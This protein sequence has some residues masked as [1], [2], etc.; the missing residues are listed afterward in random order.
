[1]EAEEE[2][3]EE[4]AGAGAGLPSSRGRLTRAQRASYAVLDDSQEERYEERAA[5]FE[6]EHGDGHGAGD[7]PLPGG[8]AV[9]AFM[10]TQLLPFQRDGVAWL[11]GLHRAGLGGILGDEM[12]LG[13]T[14]QAVALLGTLAA[15]GLLR[16]TLI[17]CPATVI[18]HWVRELTTWWPPLRVLVL[19]D[20]G[21]A[22]SAAGGRADKAATR[23][24]V[25]QTV[26]ASNAIL[27]TTYDAVRQHSELLTRPKWGYAI[28][29]EGHRIRN[30]EAAV[31]AAVKSLHTV[32][33]IVLSGAPIQ[34]RLQELW[35]LFDFVHPGRLGSLSMFE[36]QFT[37]PIAAGGWAHAT[38]LQ[39]STAVQCALVL[40]DLITPGLLRRLKRDVATQ[41][42]TK[43]EQVLFCRLS[44]AQRALYT[45]YLRSQEVA[46][47]LD[48]GSLA[49]RPITVLRK[50]CNH[51]RLLQVGGGGG[52]RTS[53]LVSESGKMS[54]LAE[55]MRMWR[56]EKRRCLLFAQGTAMLDLLEEYV[57]SEGWPYLRMD[58]GTAI[59]NRQVL[60]DAFNKDATWFV[61]LLTTRVGGVGVNLIGADRVVIFDPDWNPS[62]DTQARERA[63]RLGQ[64]K[65]VTIYRLITAGTIE[66]KIYKRQVFKTV[67]TQRVLV[68]P[69]LKRQF[70]YAD[71][72]DLFTLVDEGAGAG[73]GAAGEQEQG[74]PYEEEQWDSDE[75][76]KPSRPKRGRKRA[77]IDDEE[78]E[79]E[80]PVSRPTEPFG[81][82]ALDHLEAFHDPDAD[83]GRGVPRSRGE[84]GEEG[85][86]DDFEEEGEGEGGGRPT[87]TAVLSDIVDGSAMGT[88]ALAASLLTLPPAER[89]AISRAAV[90]RGEE[91]RRA[92]RPPTPAAAAA[93][94]APPV[95]APSPA[96]LPPLLPLAPARAPIPPTAFLSVTWGALVNRACWVGA[97]DP[98]DGTALIWAAAPNEDAAGSAALA[99]ACVTAARRTRST[100]QFPPSPLAT[101][102]PA[103]TR[104]SPGTTLRGLFFLPSRAA[105]AG[106]EPL[107]KRPGVVAAAGKTGGIVVRAWVP[108]AQR[109][110]RP[111]RPTA[112]PGFGDAGESG[113][114]ARQGAGTLRSRAI[115]ARMAD[116]R[117]AGAK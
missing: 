12:G 48:G 21:D 9:P 61:F 71:L 34:N 60:V 95:R 64:R 38:V 55:I 10:A 25:V 113:L 54:V 90:R 75:E 33:R 43:T 72:R 86:E 88:D 102:P 58:G 100:A 108:M 115:L 36:A 27:I 2:E 8:L 73:A 116:L 17:V 39:V 77:V 96:T 107:A 97:D 24:A 32:H 59:A 98:G 45:R 53:T 82:A 80:S 76:A 37:A 19:H 84:T 81:G 85:E 46:D 18:S 99:L 112:V 4:G 57:K 16:P 44:S 15:S 94:A 20:S 40:K 29:D 23:R 1:V 106:K 7:M 65:H 103:P 3:G 5:A 22:F 52:G 105:A 92:I 49:F 14:V 62:T 111:D 89:Q 110:W 11:W 70:S 117:G 56:G 47:V 114:A 41:L 13:K 109:A 30:P 26:L 91:A 83:G 68:D 87:Q 63:W 35:S 42:P 69:T 79:E 66:E 50:V 101:L 74:K 6:E 67:L 104:A 51:P 78:E 28:L 31:T 93:A